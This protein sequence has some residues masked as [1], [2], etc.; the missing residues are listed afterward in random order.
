[1]P[2]PIL[3]TRYIEENLWRAIRYGLDGKLVD[4]VMGEELP[5]TD[6]VRH[7]VELAAPT[8]DGIGLS[9]HLA[10]VERMLR[11]G[12]GAQRQARAHVEGRSLH[13]VFAGTVADAHRSSI[14]QTADAQE[15]S[16]E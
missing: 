13:E 2:L 11:D 14:G 10:D 7:L 6:A 15:S 9:P 3:E 1:M 16:D 5:A 4:W 8:A 12:N